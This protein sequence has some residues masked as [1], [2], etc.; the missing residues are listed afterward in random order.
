LYLPAAFE[1]LRQYYLSIQ[2]ANRAKVVL[3]KKDDQA[4]AASPMGN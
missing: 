4:V 2:K 3:V 1:E